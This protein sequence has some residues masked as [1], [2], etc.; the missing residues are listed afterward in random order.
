MYD[1]IHFSFRLRGVVVG[2]PIYK[3]PGSGSIADA[4][5]SYYIHAPKSVSLPSIEKKQVVLARLGFT[6]PCTP[7]GAR[8]RMHTV[9][10]LQGGGGRVSVRGTAMAK[11]LYSLN[12]AQSHL[13]IDMFCTNRNCANLLY[14]FIRK[15]TRRHYCTLDYG[16]LPTKASA[17]CSSEITKWVSLPSLLPRWSRLSALS[18]SA[19]FAVQIPNARFKQY[20]QSFICCNV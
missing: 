14:N 10:I 20:L 17:N 13:N 8:S 9:T 15:V 4:T 19:P 6:T 7:S 16:V 11:W 1:Y 12:P 18:L 5:H 2:T 3:F